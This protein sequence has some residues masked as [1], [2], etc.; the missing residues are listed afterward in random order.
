MAVETRERVGLDSAHVGERLPALRLDVAA[1]AQ[2]V[3]ERDFAGVPDADLAAIAGGNAA[4]L[5]GL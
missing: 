3:I 1:L 2:K 5:Y 4:A